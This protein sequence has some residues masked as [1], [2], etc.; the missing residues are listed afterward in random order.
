MTS[1]LWYRFEK[2]PFESGGHVLFLWSPRVVELFF[3][4][5]EVTVSHEKHTPTFV[6]GVD[7]GLFPWN[8]LCGNNHL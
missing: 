6:D 2:N 3:L 1:V 4:M 7:V 5:G 8:N